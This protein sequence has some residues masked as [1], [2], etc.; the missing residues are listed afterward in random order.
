MKHTHKNTNT[1]GIVLIVLGCI[2]LLDNFGIH[3]IGPFLIQLWPLALIFWGIKKIN[4]NEDGRNC[5]ESTKKK[6][7]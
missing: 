6:E 4:E 5:E 7:E 1:F 3:F 2:F